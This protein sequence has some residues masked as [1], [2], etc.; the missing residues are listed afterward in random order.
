MGLE[1]FGE[2]LAHPG[3]Q[4]LVNGIIIIISNNANS[5]VLEMVLF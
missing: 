3:I 1:H 4:V 5:L 2:C